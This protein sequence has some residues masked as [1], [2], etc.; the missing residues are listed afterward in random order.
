[1]MALAPV[2]SV[3]HRGRDARDHPVRRHARDASAAP[4]T[5]S[6]AST[7]RSGSCTSFAFGALAFYGL[8]ARRL[9]VGL[10]VLV[11]RRDALG[12]AADLLRGRARAVAA[13]RRDDGRLA[14]ARPRSSSTQGDGLVRRPAVRRLPHLPGRR[15]RRDRARRRSTC[16][17]PTPSSSRATTPSTAGCASARS[18]WPSTCNMIVISAASRPRCSSAAGTA[19]ARGSRPALG[20]REDVPLRLLFIW[21]RATLPRLRYDQLMS[22]GWKVLLPLATLNALVTAIAGGGH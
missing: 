22:F 14:V 4:T 3:A 20:D 5:A 6:T 8:H 21:V 9:G 15:L 18:S 13:R 16:P 2:I 12:R 11:P 10:E 1:M 19:R 17:R 7:S